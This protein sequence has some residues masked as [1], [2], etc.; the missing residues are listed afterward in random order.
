M[1]NIGSRLREARIE[2]GL[3]QGELAELLQCSSKAISRYENKDN[4]DKVYDFVKMCECLG[5]DINYIV[6]GIKK[7]MAKKL[8]CKS[9]R[10]F[11]RTITYSMMINRIL[12]TLF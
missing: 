8:L 10:Y 3:N 1:N 7:I 11:L 2:K 4:L 6:T 12:W 5:A 9:N